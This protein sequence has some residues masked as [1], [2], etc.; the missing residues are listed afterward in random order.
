[1]TTGK[2]ICLGLGVACATAVLFVIFQQGPAYDPSRVDPRLLAL[3]PPYRSVRTVI[4]MDGG[5]VGIEIIDRDGKCEKFAIPARL[6]ETNRHSKVY[7]GALYDRRPGAVEIVDPD[8][9]KRMLI[10]ILR[11][12]PHRNA[13]DDFCLM[14]LRRYP[15]DVLRVFF[16]KLAGHYETPPR[17][18]R[19]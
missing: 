4:W 16:H 13:H 8:H 1:M 9:T 18:T 17:Q 3:Q 11:D 19:Y 14:L 2:K 5:S 6:G 15:K 10:C 12:Y 7:V